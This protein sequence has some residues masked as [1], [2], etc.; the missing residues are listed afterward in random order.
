MNWCLLRKNEGR[1]F[2]SA[3]LIPKILYSDFC[4]LDYGKFIFVV[5][6]LRKSC[7]QD[8]IKIDLNLKE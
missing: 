6:P 7:D 8:T 1:G 5:S 2:V 3:R 4:Y